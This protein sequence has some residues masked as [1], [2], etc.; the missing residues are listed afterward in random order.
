VIFPKPDALTGKWNLQSLVK[1]QDPRIALKSY[2]H[3]PLAVTT[4]YLVND[5][6]TR[7]NLFMQELLAL[8]HTV[9]VFAFVVL[10]VASMIP[11]FLRARKRPPRAAVVTWD[12]QFFA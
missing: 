2:R 5:A 6:H 3:C 11:E 9:V 10:L 12:H 1:I 8:I 7:T 4:F